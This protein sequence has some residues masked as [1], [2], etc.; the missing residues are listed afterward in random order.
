MSIISSVEKKLRLINVVSIVLTKIREE[1]K[2]KHLF[3]MIHIILL[4]IFHHLRVMIDCEAIWNFFSQ[5][6]LIKIDVLILNEKLSNSRL[7][8]LDDTSL[9]IYFDYALSI[10]I[11]DINES[12]WTSKETFVEIDMYEMNMILS[13]F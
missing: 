2:I 13:L 4:R 3:V 1:T 5:S 10:E 6:K 7:K 9:M 12:K 8:I 11:I